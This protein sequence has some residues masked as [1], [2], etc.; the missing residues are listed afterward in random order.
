MDPLDSMVATRA[1]RA[2]AGSRLKELIAIEGQATGVRETFL[3]DDDENVELLFQEDE[4][5]EEFEEPQEDQSEDEESG[6]EE[7]EGKEGE[8]ENGEDED[9]DTGTAPPV[10]ADE[11][12]SDSDLSVSE[13]DESE[14]ERELEKQEK[15][16]KRKRLKTVIPTIKR[17]KVAAPPTKVATKHSLTSS[18]TLLVSQRRASSRKSAVKNK[19]ALVQRLKEDETRRAALTP[20]IRVKERD[21][22]QEERLTQAIETEKANVISLHAFL[23]QEIVKKER[24]KWMF[25]QKR[26]KLR[27]VV[28]LISR[29]TFV[30][31]LDEIEDARHVQDLFER[32]RR[33]RKKKN[34]MD[35]PEL[36]RPGDIDTELPYYRREMEERRRLEIIKMEEKRILDAA[37]AEERR[38][39]EEEKAKIEQ[40]KA[41]K[42]QRILE[43]RLARKKAKEEG[44]EYNGPE[45]EESVPATPEGETIESLVEN[46]GGEDKIEEEIAVKVESE[47]KIDDDAEIADEKSAGD[48][49]MG[50]ANP[51]TQPTSPEE[52]GD[53]VEPGTVGPEE[54]EE[55][56]EADVKEVDDVEM[57]DSTQGDAQEVKE[58]DADEKE[59][60]KVT[61]SGDVDVVEESGEEIIE[62]KLEPKQESR[63]STPTYRPRADGVIFEGPVQ[64]IARNMVYLL[65]FDE[66]QGLQR[67]S[68][69]T[70]KKVLFGEDGDL[71]ASRRFRDVRTILRSTTRGDNPYSKPM[72]EKNDELLIPVTEITEDS[73]MFE[74]LKKLR[75][76]GIRDD[77]ELEEEDVYEE[78][79]DSVNIKTEAPAG[80][81][82]PN[83]NKKICLISGREVRYFDPA[84]GIP[85]DSV[86]VYKSIKN[87]EQG[88]IPWYSIA[89]DQNTYGAVEI[90]LN[91]R[92]G[93]KHAKGVPEGFDGW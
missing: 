29:E 21:L 23:E 66:E 6:E 35:E 68:E 53:N 90:Y 82:L 79:D 46:V 3:N 69:S 73:L 27:N 17:V 50:D 26:A 30:A 39:L 78:E 28:R 1:K 76:L 54:V 71:G 5:D 59:E 42:K 11:M 47:E 49:L 40:E 4:N 62:P 85:Y 51:E 18:E 65:N 58:E 16:K 64:H 19:Q 60:K 89:K 56:L 38:K 80:L 31:P 52:N 91:N 87:V 15:A 37:Q 44:V 93:T 61:F 12:L 25:Q 10:N 67:L 81:Y 32:K 9:Q 75:R 92:E 33:G 84:T 45:L 55:L 20:I 86:D 2:N 13:D 34:F 72:E 41:E 88:I 8:E 83:G 7:T 22:T 24:Q 57:K 74:D 77:F 36:R 43:E 70:V 63:A 48:E 14:G